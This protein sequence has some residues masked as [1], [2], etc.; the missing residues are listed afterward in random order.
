MFWA[1]QMELN[2]KKIKFYC[3]RGRNLREG[4]LLYL[5]IKSKL[6][7]LLDTIRGKWDN[8]KQQIKLPFLHSLG[9]HLASWENLY[10]WLQLIN[11]LKP[12]QSRQRLFNKSHPQTNAFQCKLTKLSF[13]QS[14]ALKLHTQQTIK[15]DFN[16]FPSADDSHN[17]PTFHQV[18][19]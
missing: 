6:C 15:G 11:F 4:F 10:H 16:L 5:Q 1:P 3:S 13:I 9:R 17:L 12:L 8:I 7:A 18:Y 19:T 14:R 2:L